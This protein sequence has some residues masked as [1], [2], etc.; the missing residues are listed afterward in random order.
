M[1]QEFHDEND[2]KT[3]EYLILLI[4]GKAGGEISVLHLQKIFFF[5][6]KFHPEVRKLLEFVPHL[7]GPFSDDLDDSIKNPLYVVG[8]WKYLPPKNKSQ[9]ERAKG[10]YLVITD[11]GRET[12]KKLIE[13]LRKK[14]LEDKDAL[15]LISAVELIVPLYSK[16][17]WDELL[18]LLYTD[19]TN[20]EYSIK[21]ELS[22][23][24]LKN[25]ESIV[26]RL[27]RKGVITEDMKDALIQRAKNARWI[28]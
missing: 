17:S 1:A 16:L 26:N 7:K 23:D 22:R 25:A 3:I 27:V 9:A 21:S 24:I 18:F 20:K 6:W 4:L 2:L 13:G 5:L 12:Y 15:A 14:A 10:G 8:C 19:E 11:K 28:I